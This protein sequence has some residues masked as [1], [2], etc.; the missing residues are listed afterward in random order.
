MLKRKS[1]TSAKG[2][3]IFVFIFPA[4]FL[5]CTFVFYPLLPELVISLQK[6]DGFVNS[7]FIGL[8]NYIS[9]LTS[10]NFW[11]THKNT[12]IV[13]GLSLLVALPISML[14]A[15]LMD[16]TSPR[17]RNFFKFFSVFPAILSHA[18]V[19]RLWVAIYQDDWGIIN[20]FLRGI[21]LES[22]TRA[23][24]GEETTVMIAI[25]VAFLWQYL[26]LNALMFYAGIKVIPRT[27]FEAAEID[28]GNFFYNC[29]HITIPLL[30]DMIKY[31]VLTST[32][33]SLGMFSYVTVM[34]A[35]GPGYISRTVTYEIYQ[36][37]FGKSNF[38]EA[39]ALSVIF[40]IQC[41][42]VYVLINKFIAKE[43]V[44]Y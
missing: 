17:I 20:S 22:L 29:I 4:L 44:E 12:Y 36:L 40:L 21:G 33:G 11:L 37:A 5:F 18:V 6:H 7:G 3:E 32:L 39:C 38:G 14:F 25:A 9:V 1:L 35:G 34:S 41:I 42:L 26:G 10:K 43:A 30:Q 23:W 2:S 24:L 16:A 13:A 27:Y 15:V 8:E 31:V 19:G 28:G